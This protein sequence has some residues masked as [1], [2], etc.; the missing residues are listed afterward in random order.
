MAC[1]HGQQGCQGNNQLN[2]G[3]G[4][5]LAELWLAS[6]D[7]SASGPLAILRA[8]QI[9]TLLQQMERGTGIYLCE[10]GGAEAQLRWAWSVSVPTVSTARTQLSAGWLTCS[11][12]GPSTSYVGMR[13]FLCLCV[14]VKVL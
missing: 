14:N 8:C 7:S 11:V 6:P 2:E 9:I 4:P 10:C 1:W 13:N 5:A 3:P 12:S